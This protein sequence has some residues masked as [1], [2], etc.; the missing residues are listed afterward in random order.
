MSY[1][2]NKKLRPPCLLIFSPY[3]L[4]LHAISLV[5]VGG[6]ILS[7]PITVRILALSGFPSPPLILPRI[8]YG[9][10]QECEAP[11]AVRGQCSPHYTQK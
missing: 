11:R 5:S 2:K 10:L 4:Y 8:Y 1:P 7:K 9:Y 3:F 6:S